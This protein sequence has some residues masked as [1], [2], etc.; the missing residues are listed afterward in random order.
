MEVMLPVIKVFTILILHCL[1]EQEHPGSFQNKSVNS[2][3]SW[4]SRYILFL[5]K[6]KGKERA[7]LEG[8][9]RGTTL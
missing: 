7:F 1:W 6:L 5:A 2:P 3:F 8:A 9:R 4:V